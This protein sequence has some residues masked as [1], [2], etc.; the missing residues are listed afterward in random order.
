MHR[1]AQYKAAQISCTDITDKLS[2][3]KE[4][5]Q[6]GDSR[7]SNAVHE[8]IHNYNYKGGRHALWCTVQNFT[9]VRSTTL[10]RSPAQMLPASSQE[11][12]KTRW[13][14][15]TVG[16]SRNGNALATLRYSVGSLASLASQCPQ[17]VISYLKS[18]ILE[19]STTS[20]WIGYDWSMCTLDCLVLSRARYRCLPCVCGRPDLATAT[21]M[22]VAG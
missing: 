6:V 11:K 5:I 20:I 9:M 3:K 18:C 10:H 17:H 2:R 12:M 1:G 19:S 22:R 4:E 21:P 13:N 16:H 15:N 8:S 7:I 14:E